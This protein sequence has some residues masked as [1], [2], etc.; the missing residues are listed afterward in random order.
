MSWLLF[1]KF[2]L[3]KAIIKIKTIIEQFFLTFILKLKKK[4]II[5]TNN[6]LF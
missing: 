2:K 3:Y 4:N 5:K 6:L 1:L